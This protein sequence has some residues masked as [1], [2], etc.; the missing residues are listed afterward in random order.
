M[1]IYMLWSKS[2]TTRVLPQDKFEDTT[3]IIWNHQS[4]DRHYNGQNKI[5]KG[6]NNDLQN[7][8]TKCWATRTPT[9]TGMD[10]DVPEWL[11]V[12]ALLV[13]SVMW[14]LNDTN[15]ICYESRWTP[16][17]NTYNIYKSWIPDKLNGSKN[18]PN[19]VYTCKS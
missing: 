14:L 19:T 13:T 11:C 5:Y 12:S 17:I 6:T 18:E 1:C 8:T 2:L 10:S 4:K 15:T 3:G 9:K 7:T 16:I